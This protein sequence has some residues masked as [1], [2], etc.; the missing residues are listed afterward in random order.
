MIKEKIFFDIIGDKKIF[1]V[2]SKPD[3]AKKKIVIM[4]HGFRGS[5]IGPARAFVDFARLLN[6]KGFSTLRFD[7]PNSGNSEGDYVDSSFNEWV[8][9]T[10]YFAKKYLDMGYKVALFGQSMGATTSVIATARTEIKDKIPCIILW[11]PDPKSTFSEDPKKTE[12]EGGQKYKN[13]FWQEAKNSDFFRCLNDY[14]GKIYLAYG[15]KDRYISQELRDQVVKVVTNKG[16][17]VKIL[18]GQNHSPWEYD[19]C[20]KIY[21]EELEILERCLG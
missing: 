15:E 9:T 4:N 3:P 19:L 2:L 21:K 20:Q 14:K 6:K 12:E 18:K 8:N 13:T 11:V 1:C 7:Q 10:S 17:F 5:S 16:Q